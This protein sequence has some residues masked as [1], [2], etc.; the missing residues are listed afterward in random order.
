MNRKSEFNDALAS[1]VEYAAA[2]GNRITT[3]DIDKAFSGIVDP[4]MYDF[5]RGYLTEKKITVDGYAPADDPDLSDIDTAA[6]AETFLEMYRD[7]VSAIAPLA[8]GEKEKLL[9]RLSEGDEAARIRLVETH[10]LIVIDIAGKHA[11][12]GLPLSD[13]IQEGNLGLM[14]AV[15]EFADIPVGE[16]TKAAGIPAPGKKDVNP[17][18]KSRSGVTLSEKFDA[19]AERKVEEKMRDALDEQTSSE[20]IGGHVADRANMF[21]RETK[22]FAKE[23][24]REPTAQELAER[25]ALPVDEVERVLKISLNALTTDMPDEAGDGAEKTD[26]SGEA[27][28]NRTDAFDEAGKN[29]TD[30]FDE[31]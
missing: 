20:R 27:G 23:L 8:P 1:L 4:E 13:L 5:I 16:E 2:N 19:L 15:S 30:A 3:A 17:A 6:E 12:R 22:E 14:E 31:A 21:E 11:N 24:G 25:L 29:G 26:D 28:K 10:L 9:L 18:E 7:E